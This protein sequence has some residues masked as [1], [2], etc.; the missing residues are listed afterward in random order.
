MVAAA[1]QCGMGRRVAVG[2]PWP[3]VLLALPCVVTPM[4]LQHRG[5]LRDV[6]L[7]AVLRLACVLVPLVVVAAHNPRYDRFGLNQG[8]P[9][10]ITP[11]EVLVARRPNRASTRGAHEHVAA[12]MSPAV[13][14]VPVASDYTAPRRNTH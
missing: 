8:Q 10:V 9:W 12:V 11:A 3:A 7:P 4:L 2:V 14:A 5:A 13:R 1:D 6:T